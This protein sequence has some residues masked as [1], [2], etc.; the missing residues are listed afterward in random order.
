MK[1]TQYIKQA[2]TFLNDVDTLEDWAE[3]EAPTQRHPDDILHEQRM[4]LFKET[5]RWMGP[6]HERPGVAK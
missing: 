1:G 4:R 2:R 5:G 6:E 3:Y